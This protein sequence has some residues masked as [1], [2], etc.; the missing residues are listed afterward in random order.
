MRFSHI[1]VT[2]LYEAED[3]QKKLAGGSPFAD[4]AKTFSKCPSAAKGGDLGEVA[5]DRF[6]SDFAEAAEVLAVAQ[7]SKP[8][9]TR[10]GYHLIL[11]TS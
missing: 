1:L 7:V 2:H 9:R 3:V 10:F 6:V 4:L 5:L 11:R 8:V